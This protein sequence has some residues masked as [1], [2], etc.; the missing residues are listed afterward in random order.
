MAETYIQG[1]TIQG[2]AAADL[3]SGDVAVLGT[4][5]GIVINDAKAGDVV[6]Y[7]LDG[8][9]KFPKTTG[10]AFIA[11]DSVYWDATNKKAIAASSDHT[12]IGR[13]MYASAST[14]DTVIVRL[15][16]GS[17]STGTDASGSGS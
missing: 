16:P 17:G 15:E 9:Y 13:A 12:Y 10:T 4:F 8:A 6:A 1:N 11:G 5:V 14:V 2:T 7:Q 3:T